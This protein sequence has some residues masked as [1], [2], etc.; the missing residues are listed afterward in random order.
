MIF[1][2][3]LAEIDREA[4]AGTHHVNVANAYEIQ[5]LPKHRRHQISRFAGLA[6]DIAVTRTDDQSSL[7]VFEH[8]RPARGQAEG[9]PRAHDIV[10]PGFQHGRNG[11]VVH[12][13]L[14]QAAKHVI[15]LADSKNRVPVPRQGRGS[16]LRP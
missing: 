8:S 9:E 4:A 5:H 15:T 7:F 14:C 10:D 16:R 3:H 13:E 2:P 11:E 1:E 12:R 6:G